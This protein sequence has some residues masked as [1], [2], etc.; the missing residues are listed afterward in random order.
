MIQCDQPTIFGDAVIAAVSSVDDGPMNFR[1]HDLDEI[2][3]NRVVFLDQV[4]IEPVQ[5]TLVQVSYEERE[6]FTRYQV[7]GEEHA[8]EGMLAPTTAIVADALVTTRPEQALF[9]PLADCVGAILYDPENK[10]L[11]V[12]HLGRHSVE[13]DGGKKSVAYLVDEFD[14][15]P[16][17]LLVWLSPAVGAASY[18]LSA[19]DGRGL[20]EVVTWQLLASGVSTENIELSAVDTAEND[21]YY[22]H[23]EYKAGNQSDD[24]R[25]AIVA[26][27]AE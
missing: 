8:G 13:E 15:D 7:I 17:R 21:D 6:H 12:S 27:M 18:P 4:G 23:S 20:H 16:R 5:T 22:S 24:G 1:G 2:Q 10:I 26:M 25:F 19:F 14:T 3:H 11:M 9:L